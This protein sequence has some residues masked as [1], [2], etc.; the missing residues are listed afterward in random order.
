MQP[1]RNPYVHYGPL[2]AVGAFLSLGSLYLAKLSIEES[3]D[4][5]DGW[6]KQFYKI[7]PP[8]ALV[9]ATICTL[10]GTIFA[11]YATYNLSKASQTHFTAHYGSREG[12]VGAIATA[13]VCLLGLANALNNVYQAYREVDG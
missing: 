5:S 11:L 4:L 12:A 6:P 8:L 1:T 10:A 13:G 2:G 7:V 3:R 9:I